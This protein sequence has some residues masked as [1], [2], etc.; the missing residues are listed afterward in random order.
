MIEP[1]SL[2]IGRAVIY[3]PQFYREKEC[4]IKKELGA[5]T[6]FT[7]QTVFVKYTIL[8]DTSK[9]TNREDLYWFIPMER[10]K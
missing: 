1:T 5:I 4:H 8:G 7:D 10:D 9:V 2:D 6:S 3:Q